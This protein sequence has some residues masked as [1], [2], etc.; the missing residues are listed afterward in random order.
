MKLLAI[1]IKSCQATSVLFLIR[2]F[3]DHFMWL[4]CDLQG[5]LQ[6]RR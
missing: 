2:Q 4:S 5:S 6:V 1:F 3:N